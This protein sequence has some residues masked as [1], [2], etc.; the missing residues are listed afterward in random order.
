MHANIPP[1]VTGAVAAVGIE[2]V[3]TG[4]RYSLEEKTMYCRG[5]EETWRLDITGL[6][7]YKRRGKVERECNQLKL[8]SWHK[9]FL[10]TSVKD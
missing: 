1:G 6:P 2:A 8:I 3:L 10:T 4:E 7:F 5:K 9:K